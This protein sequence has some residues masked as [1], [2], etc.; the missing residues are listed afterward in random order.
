MVYYFCHCMC[1]H[2]CSGD[3]F[4]ILDSRFANFWE[5]NCSFGFLLIVF[6]LWC[7]CFKCALLSFGVLDGRCKVIVSILVIAFLS[8]FST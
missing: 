6:L 2:V 7:R 4:F 5:R 3:F 8:M 1:L